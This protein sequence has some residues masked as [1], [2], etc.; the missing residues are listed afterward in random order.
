MKNIK[1]LIE[2]DGSDFCGWQV[3]PDERTVQG[4][5]EAAIKKVTDQQVRIC[6][7]ARTDQGVHALGQV[8][9]FRSASDI[10]LRK[11]LRALNGLTAS[12]IYIKEIAY[13]PDDFHSRYSAKSKIY[14]YSIITQPSPLELRYNWY[15]KFKLDKESMVS[16]KD[17]FTGRH[18]FKH[19]SAE[20]E[21][22]NT[23]CTIE[24][25]SLT[26]QNSHI[27]I[28]IKG[29]RFIRKMVRG[30]VGFLYDVGRGRFRSQQ[31]E[32]ALAGRIKNIFFTPPHGLVLI[33]VFY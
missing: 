21:K 24:S 9:N 12:D 11:M 28:T 15:V 19:L 25:I 5:L 29:D 14:R 22:E 3:Q 20:N 16:A 1:M 30:I 13:A 4:D 10:P 32:D 27:I 17:L 18:D 31:V 33:R 6:G 2:Y 26:E 7:A 23:F 8:A